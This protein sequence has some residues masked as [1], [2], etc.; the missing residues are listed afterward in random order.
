MPAAKLGFES[1]LASYQSGKSTFESVLASLRTYVNLNVD[2]FGF[3][4]Q[5]L[6][7]EADIEAIRRGAR[8]GALSAAPAMEMR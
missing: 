3:L 5:E 2:Y 6:Q 1:S 4:K 7:A 8:T